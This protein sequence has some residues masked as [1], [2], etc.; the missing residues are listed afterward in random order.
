M[1][2][3]AIAMLHAV[4]R[5]D[6]ASRRLPA[7][8]TKDTREE[9]RIE[10]ADRLRILIAEAEAAIMQELSPVLQSV[11]FSIHDVHR[12]LMDGETTKVVTITWSDDGTQEDVIVDVSVEAIH[13]T[14]IQTIVRVL[15]ASAV[16][17]LRQAGL[18]PEED[19]MP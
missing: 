6:D 2:V 15:P 14:A 1:P 16:D 9:I 3:T 13:A 11:R 12:V 5:G 18:M 17:L 8:I 4:N 7:V 19:P 10:V